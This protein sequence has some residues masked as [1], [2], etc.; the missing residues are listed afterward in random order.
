MPFRCLQ[1]RLC[2]VG[3]C[4]QRGRSR[5]CVRCGRR[6]GRSVHRPRHF[7]VHDQADIVDVQAARATS[8]ATST[9]V[10]PGPGSRLS[11]C[12][13][14]AT[15]PRAPP[16]RAT[17]ML[18]LPREPIVADLGVHEHDRR[19]A[20]TAQILGQERQLFARRK[21]ARFVRDGCAGPRREPTCMNTA[22]GASASAN[23]MTS[24]GIVAEKSIVWRRS[25]GAA[26][27]RSCGRRARSPCPSCGRLRR[28]R[29]LR[30]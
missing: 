24:S 8:V 23:R 27:Q 13:P 20:F 5:R 12:A 3:E 9:L 22:S 26:L 4:D 7:V 18:Q 21:D 19:A 25:W 2:L 14:S 11:P 6:D 17:R 1:C 29:T 30:P 28:A 15:D 16:P 10:R